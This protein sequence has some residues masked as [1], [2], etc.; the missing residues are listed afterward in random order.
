[1]GYVY[2]DI[3]TDAGQRNFALKDIN[4]SISRIH[5]TNVLLIDVYGNRYIIEDLDKLERASYKQIETYLL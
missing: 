2:F 1:M 3:E 5:D 4:K